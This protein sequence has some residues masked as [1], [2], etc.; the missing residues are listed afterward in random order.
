MRGSNFIT[1]Q[2]CLLLLQLAYI[3][4]TPILSSRLLLNFSLSRQDD[5]DIWTHVCMLC[6]EALEHWQQMWQ[7]IF[8]LDLNSDRFEVCDCYMIRGHTARQHTLTGHIYVSQLEQEKVRLL[9]HATSFL[10]QHA[11][12]TQHDCLAFR[13]CESTFRVTQE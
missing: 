10:G 4:G 2:C 11:P 7:R 13:A 9:T 8:L 3:A 6:C 12:G 5:I 1:Y